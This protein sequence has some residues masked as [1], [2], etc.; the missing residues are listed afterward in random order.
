MFDDVEVLSA[1]VD[2]LERSLI[3]GLYCLVSY[4]DGD[5][6]GGGGGE[7]VAGDGLLDVMCR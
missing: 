2:V 7:H 5:D 6:D 1:D 3:G 4:H